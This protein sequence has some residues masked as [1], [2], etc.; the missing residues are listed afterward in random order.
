ML[1]HYHG[2]VWNASEFARSLGSSAKT[3]TR[4]LDLLTDAYVVRQLQPWHANIKKR[5]VKAPKVYLRD[6]GILHAL[7]GLEQEKEVLGHPKCGASWEGF[8]LEQIAHLGPFEELYYW[9]TH[10]GAE[11]DALGFCQGKKYGFEIKLSDAPR[12]SKSM[13]IVLDDLELDRLSIIYPGQK[14]YGLS[15]SVRAVSILELPDVLE[16]LGR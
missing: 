6:S 7:L 15:H 11:I 9:A 13:H 1:A 16:G 2:Q 3:A 8:V 4:Y 10:A 14:S 12:M 5:Q